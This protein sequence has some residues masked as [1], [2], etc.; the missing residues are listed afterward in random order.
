M[1]KRNF[2]ASAAALIVLLFGA[3]ALFAQCGADGM[4]PC[5]KTP[6]K[7]TTTKKPTTKTTVTK[8]KPTT[9]NSQTSVSKSKTKF[10]PRVPQIEMVEIPAGF[11]DIGSKIKNNKEKN[12]ENKEKVKEN[13]EKNRTRF[14]FPNGFYMG[15]YEVT[16]VQWQAVMG[17]NPSYFKDCGESCPVNQVSWDDTKVFISK[18][19]SLQSDYKYRLPTEAEWEYAFR[20]GT[21]SNYTASLDSMAWYI[22]NS[23]DKPHPVGQKSPN[24]WGLYDMLGNV[25]EWCEDSIEIDDPIGAGNGPNRVLRGGSWMDS[26]E[27]FSELSGGQSPTRRMVDVGFRL[28]RQ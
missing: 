6:K 10:V 15:K 9:K 3:N 19:N 12:K 24:K 26:T 5:G 8:S 28:V 2:I 22:A 25:N 20:A 21:T 7:I 14:Y 4:Q 16:Q 13:N 1:M 18:L 23:G 17:Y 27:S 11:I